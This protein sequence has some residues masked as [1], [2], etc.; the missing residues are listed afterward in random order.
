L[1][2]IAVRRDRDGAI[3]SDDGGRPKLKLRKHDFEIGGFVEIAKR[4]GP[5]SLEVQAVGRAWATL[6]QQAIDWDA[7]ELAAAG[8]EVLAGV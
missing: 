5:E 7:A 1:F 4:H 8:D 6:T 3:K 2:H